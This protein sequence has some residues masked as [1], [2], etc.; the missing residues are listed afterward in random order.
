MDFNT[1]AKPDIEKSVYA[2]AALLSFICFLA[3][4][5]CPVFLETWA[6]IKRY[7][8]IFMQTVHK[9]LIITNNT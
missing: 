5:I 8:I 4:G 6:V 9:K 7:P 3:Q 1:H 2:G